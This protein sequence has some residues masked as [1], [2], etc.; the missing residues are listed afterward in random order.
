MCEFTKNDIYSD[1]G[2]IINQISC[3]KRKLQH[4]YQG[5]VTQVIH[6]VGF[7]IIKLTAFR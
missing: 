6:V 3:L 5:T 2:N 4:N 1:N 7:L